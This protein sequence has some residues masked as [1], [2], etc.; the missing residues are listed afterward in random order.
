MEESYALEK[1]TPDWQG[2]HFTIASGKICFPHLCESPRPGGQS[3]QSSHRVTPS[4]LSTENCL[5]VHVFVA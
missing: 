5:S 4:A 2:I 3:P 1:E